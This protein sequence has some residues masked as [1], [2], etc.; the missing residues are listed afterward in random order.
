MNTRREFLQQAGIAA[1]ALSLPW[2]AVTHAQQLLPRRVIPGTSESLPIVGLG[3]GGVFIEGDVDTSRELMGILRERGGSYMDCLFAA[4]DTVAR[5]VGELN[6]QDDFFMGAYVMGDTEEDSRKEIAEIL[7]TSGKDAIDLIHAW[8]EFAVPN[9]DM[10]RGWK[11]DGLG[12]YIG[13]SRNASE[14]YDDILQLM[15]T[16]TVDIVQVN[17]SAL[18]T[19]AADRILPLAMDKGIAVNINRPF[20]NGDFFSLVSGH[21][22][23]AWAADFDCESWA[24]FSLKFILSHPAVNCVITETSKPHHAI[25]NI[26]AG[27]GRMPDE[28]ERRRMVAH[29]E[30]LSA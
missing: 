17:Y 19:E 26:G 16:G 15:N 3:T 8:N 27:F 4:R 25:D 29:L 6:A 28:S 21:E 14:H 24:Q 30:G 20:L 12:R 23:P 2:S 1:A 18:E 7:A 11:E 9:W 5:V 10:I 22:L 13:V